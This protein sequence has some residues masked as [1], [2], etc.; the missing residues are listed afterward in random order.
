[1]QLGNTSKMVRG[2]GEK[3]YLH[4]LEGCILREYFVFCHDNQKTEI[5][6]LGPWSLPQDL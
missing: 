3:G 2:G 4:F 5:L 1:M 6:Q